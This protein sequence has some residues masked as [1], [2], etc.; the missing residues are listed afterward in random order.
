LIP[1]RLGAR[2]SVSA[3]TKNI[4]ANENRFQYRLMQEFLHAEAAGFSRLWRRGNMALKNRGLHT[5]F[6][7]S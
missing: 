2:K 3:K 6:Q 4:S 7:V 5:A 1:L